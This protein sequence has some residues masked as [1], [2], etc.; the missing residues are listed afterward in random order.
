MRYEVIRNP[1]YRVFFA[2][3]DLAPTLYEM[4]QRGESVHTPC[5][6]LAWMIAKLGESPG[7]IRGTHV[8]NGNGIV[9]VLTAIRTSTLTGEVDWDENGLYQRVRMPA[10]MQRDREVTR[11]EEYLIDTT[12]RP[13]RAGIKEYWKLHD[14]TIISPL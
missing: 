10:E 14:A 13:I 8:S 3:L 7:R 12:G 1:M 6:G 11:Y 9:S 4:L 2:H 5:C